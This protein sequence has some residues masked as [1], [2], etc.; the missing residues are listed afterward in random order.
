MNQPP[1]WITDRLEREAY[2]D[3]D[4]ISAERE[5]RFNRPEYY[6]RK[7]R[8]KELRREQEQDAEYGDQEKT[9]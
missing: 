7:E 6:R 9:D 1:K 3:I 8:E 5:Y 2:A 4:E